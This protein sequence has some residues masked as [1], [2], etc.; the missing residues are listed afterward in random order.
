MAPSD[1]QQNMYIFLFAKILCNILLKIFLLCWIKNRKL[2]I[3][4]TNARLLLSAVS[5]KTWV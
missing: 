4:L 5:V 2:Y 3:T 1:S